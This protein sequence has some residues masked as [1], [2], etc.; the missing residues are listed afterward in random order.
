MWA[1]V[2]R[3]FPLLGAAGALLYGIGLVAGNSSLALWG[4]YDPDPFRSSLVL[5]GLLFLS[6][7]ACASIPSWAYSFT[8]KRQ[9]LSP[10]HPRIAGFIMAF[11][12]SLV[13]LW[14]YAIMWTE[15][16]NQDLR[17][18]LRSCGPI[19]LMGASLP[20]FGAASAFRNARQAFAKDAPASHRI[21]MLIFGP[22]CA[23][24]LLMAF[25]LVYIVIPSYLGG[26]RP[27]L[28]E[29]WFSKDAVP[30]LQEYGLIASGNP[31]GTLVKVPKVWVLYSRG[32]L[33][34]FCGERNCSR[35]IQ[36]SKDW[37]KS[38]SW[39]LAGR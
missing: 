21:G 37:V 14:L 11:L 29:V 35:A 9:R 19:I 22:F 15:S 24:V 5:T 33:F 32:D 23:Y 16:E 36:V 10:Q 39:P 6:Y 13:L 17:H 7:V 30:T 18:W 26:G 2:L 8:I 25:S 12:I 31:T 3:K 20:I 38:E 27:V 4:I 34:V 1:S 28:K